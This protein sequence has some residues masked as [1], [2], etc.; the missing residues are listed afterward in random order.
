M[1]RYGDLE[2]STAWYL[3]CDSAH[4][5]LLLNTRT[6]AFLKS[7]GEPVRGPYYSLDICVLAACS[8]SSAL[9]YSTTRS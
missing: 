4:G 6:V 5:A 8:L 3:T 7:I 1:S 9:I 2:N